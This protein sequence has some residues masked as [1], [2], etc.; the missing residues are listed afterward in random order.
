[1]PKDGHSGVGARLLDHA[2]QKN[3]MVVLHQDDRLLDV[4]RFFQDRIREFSVDLLV[5]APVGGSKQR[6]GVCYVAKRPQ[7]LVGKAIVITFLFFLTQP[8]TSQGIARVV[9]RNPQAVIEVH[10]FAVG[11]A[12]AMSDPGAI[13][14]LQ[15]WLQ[16][17]DQTT[18]GN[19]YLQVLSSATMKIWLPVGYRD[20]T[21]IP[22]FAAHVHCQ[23]VRCPYGFRR[24]PQLG[25]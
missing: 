19:D 15:H 8:E 13:A 2:W 6:T 23:P 21:A 24:F 4:L 10:G 12:A 7:T 9:G 25:L 5:I 18:G 22:Q 20:Q 3:E 17:R 16:S 1:M 11:I 14:G